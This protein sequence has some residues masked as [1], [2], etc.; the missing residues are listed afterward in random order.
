MAGPMRRTVRPRAR[1][2]DGRVARRG[3]HALVD[4]LER[5]PVP[6][7]PLV[8]RGTRSPNDDWADALRAAMQGM[9][10]DEGPAS[11]AHPV[12]WGAFEILIYLLA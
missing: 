1:L 9:I 3:G 7:R 8:R 10:E 2:P 12:N 5:H 6:E 4:P 11:F